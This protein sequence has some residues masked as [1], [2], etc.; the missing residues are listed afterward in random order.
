MCLL[1]IGDRI[2]ENLRGKSEG[3]WRKEKAGLDLHSAF[4]NDDYV[5]IKMDVKK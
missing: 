2:A 1:P 5:E 3:K 4:K